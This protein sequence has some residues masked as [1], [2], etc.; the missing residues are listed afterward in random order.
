MPF[1]QSLR[2]VSKDFPLYL[3]LLFFYLFPA[4]CMFIVYVIRLFSC[5][6]CDV[7]KYISIIHRSLQLVGVITNWLMIQ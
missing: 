5:S 3:C 2:Y 6:I 7:H 4:D 1:L